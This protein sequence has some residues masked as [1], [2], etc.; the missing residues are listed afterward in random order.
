MFSA[1]M[2]LCTIGLMVY[3]SLVHGIV[4]FAYQHP[5]STA[6]LHIQLNVQLCRGC[7]LTSDDISS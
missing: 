4:Q 7:E 5:A 6:C 2:V 1:L 3:T